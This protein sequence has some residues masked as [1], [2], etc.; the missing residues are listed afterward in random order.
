MTAY[1]AIGRLFA[2]DW[3]VW[4]G[5][6]LGTEVWSISRDAPDNPYVFSVWR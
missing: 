4:D 6:R 1:L 3:S 2:P 5:A